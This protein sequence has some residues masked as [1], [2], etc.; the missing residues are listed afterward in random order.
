MLLDI[1][2]LKNGQFAKR[3][4]WDPFFLGIR[5]S[6]FLLHELETEN[7]ATTSTSRVW[8]PLTEDLL[9]D[10][11]EYFLDPYGYTKVKENLPPVICA[12]SSHYYSGKQNP[13]I[14]PM[15]FKPYTK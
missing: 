8:N 3:K 7:T 12:T 6:T 2:R 10:D 14:Q 5:N 9:A 11:W 1:Q 13:P 4:S 15:F